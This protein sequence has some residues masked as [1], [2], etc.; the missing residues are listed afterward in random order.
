MDEGDLHPAPH[1]RETG[2]EDKPRQATAGDNTDAKRTLIS[3]REGRSKRQRWIALGLEISVLFIIALVLALFLQAFLVKPFIIPSPSMEPTLKEG[4][5]VLSDRVT[6]QF[7]EPR[8]GEIVVFRFPP[9]N[10][11]NWTKGRN[12][13]TRSLDLL[14]EVLNITHQDG[15]PPFIKRVVGVGGD[16]VELRDGVLYVNGEL[17]GVDYDYVRDNGNG[18]W[19]VPEGSVM[20]MGD[21]RPNSNDSRRWGFV[22]LKAILGRA[23]AIWWPPG[24]WSAL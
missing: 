23:V 3:G 2:R 4:D 1:E 18:K 15:H 24:R 5:R 21:N 16:T 13:L 11:A 22:S 8:R 7:R 19:E 6:Y 12:T 20:V 10:P 14:A 9:D 17:E